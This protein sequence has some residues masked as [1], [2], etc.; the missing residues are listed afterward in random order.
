[1]KKTKKA[2]NTSPIKW[3]KV[4]RTK[5]WGTIKDSES[6]D[7]MM[8]PNIRIHVYG[9]YSK[10]SKY[11]G[12]EGG[13]HFTVSAVRPINYPNKFLSG[14]TIKRLS[15]AKDLAVVAGLM[16][17]AD[18]LIKNKKPAAMELPDVVRK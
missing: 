13:W 18:C 4:D 6:H 5:A 10:H 2:S 7:T 14:R 1:L 8:G 17:F 15:E 16:F 12:R 9:G 11:V 3:V